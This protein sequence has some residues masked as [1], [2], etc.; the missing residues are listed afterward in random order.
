MTVLRRIGVLGGM[1]PEATVLFQ[2]RLIDATP[3]RDDADHLPLIVDMN[4]QVPSRISFLLEGRGADPAP[5][6]AQ[7]ARRLHAAGAEALVMPCNTAHS[8][9]SAI[10]A[11]TPLPLLSMV[12]ASC[13][14]ATG[15]RSIGIIGSPALR[16]TG[17]FEATI[18]DCGAT[19]L[20][21]ANEDALLAAIR[22]IKAGRSVSEARAAMR[23]AADDL[24]SRGADALLVA[25]SE[26][27]LHADALEAKGRVIDTLDCLVSVT[28]AFGRPNG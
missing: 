5:V 9:A 7:M 22:D 23:N 16:R 11:A 8:F 21:P 12:A 27:S 18:G 15:A 2:Q 20:Y 14:A 13:D 19:A 24:L 17:V 6:L 4:P 26:F 1:G 25:C 3:A 28:I 10:E